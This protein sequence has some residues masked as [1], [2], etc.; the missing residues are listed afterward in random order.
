MLSTQ[1][2]RVR[3]AASVVASDGVIAY[4]TE[5]VWGL[6]CNP[7]SE[8]AVRR[9]LRLKAR[10]ESKGLI[11]VAASMQQFDWLLHDLPLAQKSRLQLSWPGAT[12]WLVPHH[13]RVPAWIS[14]ANNSVALRVSSHPRVQALCAAINSPIVSTSANLS[15]RRE[16]RHLFQVY[17]QFGGGLDYV[18]SGSLG[19][20]IRP[21]TIRDLLTDTLVRPG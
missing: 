16:A 9:L 4:P 18:L 13:N 14:G 19:G 3:I 11:L 6:G 15:G 12:T 1:D 8:V 10:P 7:W 17:Q 20:N 21:S 5:A 2:F